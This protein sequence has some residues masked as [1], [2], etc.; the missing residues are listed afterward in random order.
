MAEKAALV[1]EL[2]LWHVNEL[3]QGILGDTQEKNYSGKR[4]GAEV[5]R[6]ARTWADWEEAEAEEL[7]RSFKAA[8]RKLDVMREETGS[9]LGFHTGREPG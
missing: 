1:W 4:S 2:V 8:E 9:D 3:G 5:S 6:V 7:Q